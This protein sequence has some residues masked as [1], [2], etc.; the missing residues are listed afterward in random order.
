MSLLQE[1]RTESIEVI[2]KRLIEIYG[3]TTDNRARFRIVWSGDQL[4]KRYGTFTEYY[5]NIFLREVTCV[6]EVKK[7]DYI[8]PAKYVLEE[9]KYYENPEIPFEYSHYEALWSFMNKER[10]PLWPK[11]DIVKIVVES[12]LNSIKKTISDYYDEDQKALAK[13]IL[14]FEEMLNGDSGVHDM[15][16]Q[17]VAF[18]KPVFL[19]GL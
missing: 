7:Y 1:T 2:N 9:L 18:V 10:E 8:V 4:E 19:G 6:K 11:W 3:R 5:G 17:T 14:E 13:E 15:K 12:R 16:N